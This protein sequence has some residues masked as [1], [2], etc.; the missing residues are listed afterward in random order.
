MRRASSRAPEAPPG[1]PCASAGR[2]GAPGPAGAGARRSAAGAGPSAAARA[3]RSSRST[4]RAAS[5]SR[6]S[7]G[8]VAPLMVERVSCTRSPHSERSAGANRAAW[9][10]IA[11]SSSAGTCG[12]RSV[13]LSGTA[14]STMRSRIRSSRSS[15]KRRG[16]WPVA[17]TCST[18]PYSDAASRSATAVIARSSRAVSVKPSSAIAV[19]KSS[20]SSPAPAIS[21]SSTDIE[22]RAEPPP[23][24]TTS[25][26]TPSPTCTCS[27]AQTS[28]RYGPSTCG[29][30]RRNG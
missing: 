12:S 26:I 30:I 28:S 2:A 3:A 24:R 10:R 9:P 4:R 6:W 17:S 16:S 22:S 18:A 8:E 13:P 23:A 1:A 5:S 15:T 21:W 11:S 20:P 29:G 14:E 25:G 27:A 19:G 7:R